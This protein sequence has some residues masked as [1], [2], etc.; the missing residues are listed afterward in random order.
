[1][2]ENERNREA[3]S[4]S[5]RRLLESRGSRRVARGA[6]D[7]V[8]GVPNFRIANQPETTPFVDTSAFISTDPGRLPTSRLLAGT[9]SV[10]VHPTRT[11]ADVAPIRVT[12]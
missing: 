5:G 2:R 6:T 10:I 3:F 12:P 4:I 7:T 1:M 8:A 9:S 11:D